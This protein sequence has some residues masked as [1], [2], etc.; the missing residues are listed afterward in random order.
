MS[1]FNFSTLPLW[2]IEYDPSKIW[3]SRSHS[4]W[5][6]RNDWVY[7]LILNVFIKSNKIADYISTKVNELRRWVNDIKTCLV[8]SLN[9]FHVPYCKY[10]GS[11]TRICVTG[12]LSKL[13]TS[14]ESPVDSVLDQRR[15]DSEES[16]PLCSDSYSRA[17]FVDHESW[18]R[19]WT[20]NSTDLYNSHSNRY[21]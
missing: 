8:L 7:E 17:W 4:N 20:M 16:N 6:G 15:F 10:F 2:S 5:T 1:V 11:Q 14:I 21:F 3:I 13:S 18:T 12:T 19:P 9:N